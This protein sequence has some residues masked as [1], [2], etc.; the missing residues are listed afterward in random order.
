MNYAD[1]F[2]RLLNLALRHGKD[3]KAYLEHMI[4]TVIQ[5]KLFRSTS[6]YSLVAI[7]K[8]CRYSANQCDKFYSDDWK[9]S[10]AAEPVRMFCR[11]VIL[12]VYQTCLEKA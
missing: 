2:L 11:A 5:G 3:L 12:Q 8:K 10:F 6:D 4:K 7:I 1:T 9:H